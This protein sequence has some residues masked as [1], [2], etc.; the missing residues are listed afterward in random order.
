MN[1][2]LDDTVLT[3]FMNTFYG[4]GNYAGDYWLVGMEEAGV[5]TFNDIQKRLYQ[6]Q[7]S[8]SSEL[9]NLPTHGYA[10]GWGNRYFGDNPKW[11]PTWGKLIRLILTAQGQVGL[12]TSNIKHFQKEH[13]G[14]HNCNHCLI[15]L[16]PL[17]AQST[18][19][20]IY[21][22]HS[23]LPFLESRKRYLDHLAPSR[24]KHIQ[25][26]IEKHQPKAVIF[27]G[28]S[29]RDWWQEIAKRPFT[30][31]ENPKWLTTISNNTQYYVIDHPV[32]T[33]VTNNYF[34]QIG[35]IIRRVKHD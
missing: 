21:T 23:K 33:G 7:Q 22:Q 25:Q 12:N 13:L 31:H 24:I 9:E 28:W 18:R 14:Q 17:P 35:T 16:F 30:K 10:M 32:A 2:L 15:E 5:R 27:Y 34:E 11:Q 6:W 4:F 19:H 8:G 3:K 26:R 1:H 20:W 29:Y